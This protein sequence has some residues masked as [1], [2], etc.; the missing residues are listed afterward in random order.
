MPA[1]GHFNIHSLPSQDTRHCDRCFELIWLTSIEPHT[2]YLLTPGNHCLHEQTTT[3]TGYQISFSLEFLYDNGIHYTL[4]HW[5]VS[6]TARSHVLHDDPDIQ[7]RIGHIIRDINREY[8]HSTHLS[9]DIISGLLNL[10]LLYLKRRSGDTPA[11]TTTET[12]MVR[13]FLTS[14]KRQFIT[15][16]LVYDYAL[17]LSITPNY[18]NRVV[19]KLTGTTASD[20]IRQQIVLE[21]KRQIITSGASMK[22][23]AYNLGFDNLAHFSKFF[24]NKSGQNYTAF[25]RS[26]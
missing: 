16:R 8:D 1:P 3:L 15:K 7:L 5:L 14:V 24:K 23:V 9:A 11:P 10:L 26:L 18:L 2:L 19:K 20:H 25:K 4:T 17:E 22:Q 21:A 13:N 6:Q 12:Q